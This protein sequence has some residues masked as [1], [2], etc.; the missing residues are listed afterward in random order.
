[1]PTLHFEIEI[2]P[3]LHA[4]WSFH[5][6]SRTNLPTTSHCPG[7]PPPPPPSPPP[8][9]KSFPPPATP[10]PAVSS[11]P[12]FSRLACGPWTA[13]YVHRRVIPRQPPRQSIKPRKQHPL[14]DIRLVQL[15]PHLP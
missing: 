10:R 2:E 3:P 5:P 6:A 8:A 1:M 11:S 9:P 13:P 14:G 12:P 4:G 15:I 7:P